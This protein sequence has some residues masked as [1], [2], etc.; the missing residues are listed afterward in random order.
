MALSFALTVVLMGIIGVTGLLSM[1]GIQENLNHIFA[2]N[3]PSLDY[4]VEA[5][6]DLQQLLVAERSMIFADSNS[7]V[8][9]GLVETY[10]ENLQQAKD[11]FANFKAL[12]THAED[13]QAAADFEAARVGCWPSTCPSVWLPTNS[14]QCGPN[15]ICS[16]N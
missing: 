1:R 14:K 5:D 10:E 12:I 16:S 2:V 11:R 15:W 13:L 3:L 9:Q 6:R 4:V 8:F 7:E